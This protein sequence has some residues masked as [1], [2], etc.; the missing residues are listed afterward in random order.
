MAFN[1]A[2]NYSAAVLAF[3]NLLFYCGHNSSFRAYVY[4]IYGLISQIYIQVTPH[5]NAQIYMA[6]KP[7]PT[8]PA[9]G[10]ESHGPC[11]Y[12]FLLFA[13]PHICTSAHLHIRTS[14]HLHIVRPLQIPA[15]FRIFEFPPA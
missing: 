1:V 3:I 15:K 11:F 8:P 9:G 12:I 14:T 7:L 10:R 5:Y 4:Q 13:H 6:A 2:I